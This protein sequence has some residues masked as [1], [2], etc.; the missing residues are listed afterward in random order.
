MFVIS[1]GFITLLDLRL[2]EFLLMFIRSYLITDQLPFLL[3][4]IL[5]QKNHLIWREVHRALERQHE[6]KHRTL[7]VHGTTEVSF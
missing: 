1:S 7:S 2:A 5:A 6:E 3:I 4:V